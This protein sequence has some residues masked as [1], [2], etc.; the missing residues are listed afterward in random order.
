MMRNDTGSVLTYIIMRNRSASYTASS[1]SRQHQLTAKC[2]SPVLC[3]RT[4]AAGGASPTVVGR[5]VATR[6]KNAL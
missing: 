5:G 4:R 3:K 1:P 2:T 6:K